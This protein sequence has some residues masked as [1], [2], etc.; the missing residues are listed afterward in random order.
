[1]FVVLVLFRMDKEQ[2]PRC[3]LFE[4]VIAVV[5]IAGIFILYPFTQQEPPGIILHSIRTVCAGTH[6]K[7]YPESPKKSKN[8]R[9]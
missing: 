5:L 9:Q 6:A 8:V 4:W 2:K 1:M 3:T 7:K